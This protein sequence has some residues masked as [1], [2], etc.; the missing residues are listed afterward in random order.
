MDEN[1]TLR[2]AEQVPEKCTGYIEYHSPSDHDRST[3]RQ[4]LIM[5]AVYELEEETFALIKKVVYGMVM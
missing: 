2:F 5:R 4:L 1:T 3:D